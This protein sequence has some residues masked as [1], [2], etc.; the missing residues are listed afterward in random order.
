MY[1][2]Q[3]IAL[4]YQLNDKMNYHSCNSRKCLHRFTWIMK[5]SWQSFLKQPDS[6]Y[7]P[8]S[9]EIHVLSQI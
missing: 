2:L 7:A 1:F 9:T 8:D 5:D 4:V 6:T 3:C